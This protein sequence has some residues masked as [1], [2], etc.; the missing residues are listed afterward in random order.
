MAHR[1]LTNLW[2]GLSG[3]FSIWWTRNWYCKAGIHQD[4]GHLTHRNLIHHRIDGTTTEEVRVVEVSVCMVCGRES[5][6]IFVP[7]DMPN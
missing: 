3:W 2:I 6:S 1:T 7:G 5:V 4:V